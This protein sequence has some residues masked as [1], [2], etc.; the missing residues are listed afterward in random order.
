MINQESILKAEKQLIGCALLNSTIVEKDFG[1]GISDNATEIDD[2]KLSFAWKAIVDLVSQGKFV[3]KDSVKRHAL[4]LGSDLLPDFEFDSLFDECIALVEDTK[5]VRNIAERVKE[6]YI[7]SRVRRNSDLVSQ[8]AYDSGMNIEEKIA[9]I[10]SISQI[11]FNDESTQETT[12]TL[13]DSTS[14][15]IDRIMKA[16]DGETMGVSTGFS[17]LD[18]ML[19][20]GLEPGELYIIAARP[21]MG[22][23]TLSLDV[24]RAVSEAGKKTFYASVEMPETQL[25]LKMLAANSG[26]EF[27]K[28]K[29]GQLNDDEFTSLEAAI[30]K[31]KKYDQ[32]FN[33]CIDNHLEAI[34]SKARRQKRKDGLDIIF[35]DYLQLLQTYK[36]FGGNR[37]LEVSHIS[38]SLKALAKELD[39]PV[40]ALSQL[41]RGLETRNDPRPKNSDLRDSGSIEQDA[42]AIIFIHRDE[43]YKHDSPLK[44]FAE[45]IIG[46]NRHGETGTIIAKSR[47]EYSEFVE[48]DVRDLDHLT[49]ACKQAKISAHNVA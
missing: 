29:K 41:N 17:D 13:R 6:G 40:V 25:A 8:A 31:Q 36:N 37:T 18:D 34:V 47:L 32:H 15:L 44:G 16:A 24:A 12:I 38:N 49:D 11:E 22:K 35:V 10:E 9:K 33:V 42:T 20:S 23:T 19:G 21:G 26:V 48:I 3:D 7:I 5:A 45:F 43:V 39:V 1:L 46:K 14:K 4:Y 27:G 30:A 2:I 28:I